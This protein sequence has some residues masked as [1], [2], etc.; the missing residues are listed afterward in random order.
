VH[1]H[2]ML[3]AIILSC[4]QNH[5]SDHKEIKTLDKYTIATS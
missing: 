2:L 4:K 1:Q 3:I 5:T